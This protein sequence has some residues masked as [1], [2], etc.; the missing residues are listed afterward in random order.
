VSELKMPFLLLLAAST[1]LSLILRWL[2]KIFLAAMKTFRRQFH[3][4]GWNVV[5]DRIYFTR[6][7]GKSQHCGVDIKK[8][9]DGGG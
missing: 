4:L 3:S 1:K 9:E 8:L 6:E 7:N 5:K 2:I